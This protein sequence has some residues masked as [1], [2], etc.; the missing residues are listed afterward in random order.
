MEQE[1]SYVILKCR[2]CDETGPC[3]VS[4]I[5]QE[6]KQRGLCA[7]CL[8]IIDKI[9]HGEPLEH[10]EECE[11]KLHQEDAKDTAQAVKRWMEIRD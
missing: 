3:P 1:Y 11:N 6:G 10:D 5:S 8:V 9:L 4:C 7:A 2:M